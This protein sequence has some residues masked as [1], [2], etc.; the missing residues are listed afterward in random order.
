MVLSNDSND[1]DRYMNDSWLQ[2]N[3]KGYAFQFAFV[4]VKLQTNYQIRG[5]SWMV[6]G[7][8]S[9]PPVPVLSQ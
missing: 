8:L 9:A 6:Q 7:L 3:S 2:Y 5:R 4:T 1:T